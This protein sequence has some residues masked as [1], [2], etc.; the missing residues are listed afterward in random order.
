[1][2][3][4][5]DAAAKRLGLD[6]S[7]ESVSLTRASMLSSMGGSLG[8]A[9]SVSPGFVFL[10]FWSFSRDAASSAVAASAVALAFIVARLVSK[11][12]ATQA[13]VGAA[14]VAITAFM[15]LRD[16][17]AAADYFIPGF[18]TNIAYGTVLLLS[19]LIR[20][21]LIGLLVGAL[22]GHPTAWR[23]DSVKIKLFTFATAIW[24]AMF[25]LRLLVQLPLYFANQIEALGIARLVMGLPLYAM[26]IWLTWLMVRRVI[27]NKNN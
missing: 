22:T 3:D 14:G 10:A 26:T 27:S 17:G 7:G 9:E 23:R 12:S 15:V 5:K 20:W 18:I 13:L 1:M 24:V 19:I 21:P 6:L 4:Q 25:G 8:I 16:G 2:S 11:K